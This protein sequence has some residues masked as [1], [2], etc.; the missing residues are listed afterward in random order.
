[1]LESSWPGQ[2][3]LSQDSKRVKDNLPKLLNSTNLA[4]AM[5]KD[6]LRLTSARKQLRN[7]LLADYSVVL[8]EMSLHS[9]TET[10]Y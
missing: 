10:R 4:H 3:K 6:S 7:A 5:K 2:P 1:M 9:R 8:Q